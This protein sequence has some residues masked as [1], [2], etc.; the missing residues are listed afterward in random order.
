M[1][2][3]QNDGMMKVS[4]V[5]AVLDDEP[6]FGRALARL[7]REDGYEVELFSDGKSLLT[8][9]IRKPSDCI[10]LDLQMPEM[11]GFAVLQQLSAKENMRIPVIIVTAHD[12]VSHRQRAASLGASDYLTKP[13]DEAILLNAIRTCLAAG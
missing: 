2:P 10:L 4:S 9:Q 7:L 11:D 5:V 12:L 1:K 8:A 3:L 13:V 6:S